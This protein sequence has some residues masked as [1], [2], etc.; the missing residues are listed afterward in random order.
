MIRPISENKKQKW[1]QNKV[2]HWDMS[3][4]WKG[5]GMDTPSHFIWPWEWL[6]TRN[7]SLCCEQRASEIAWAWKCSQANSMLPKQ[8]IQRQ[9]ESQRLSCQEKKKK[10]GNSA[11]LA[12]PKSASFQ[13]PTQWRSHSHIFPPFLV[14]LNHRDLILVSYL[15]KE[16]DPLKPGPKLVFR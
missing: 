6:G 3:D 7:W 11:F 10:K 9:S 16:N 1:K 12:S 2:S 13:V 15:Q 8:G 5:F 14:P 4:K